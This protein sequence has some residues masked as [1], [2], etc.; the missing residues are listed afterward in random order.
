MPTEIT[1][2]KGVINLSAPFF[3]ESKSEVYGVVRHHGRNHN[4][5]RYTALLRMMANDGILMTR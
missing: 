2:P 3:Q 4:D 1:I 5:N